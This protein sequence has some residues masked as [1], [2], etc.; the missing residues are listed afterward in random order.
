MCDKTRDI[1]RRANGLISGVRM[2]LLSIPSGLWGFEFRAAS[3]D[4]L[5][6]WVVGSFPG[7]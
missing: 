1:D 6:R 2:F 3:L 7:G 4:C 5:G